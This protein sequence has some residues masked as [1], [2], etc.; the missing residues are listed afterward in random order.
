MFWVEVISLKYN[1]EYIP[2]QF[3]YTN[4]LLIEEKLLDYSTSESDVYD[5]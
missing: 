3:L 5:E 2:I 1:F 4:K